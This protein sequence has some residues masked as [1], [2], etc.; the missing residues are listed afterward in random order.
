M[1]D[2]RGGG[3]GPVLAFAVLMAALLVMMLT[4]CTVGPD[5]ERPRMELPADYG[6]VQ[7]PVPPGQKWWSVFGDPVLD[8]VIDEALAANHDLKAAAERIEAARGRLLVARAPLTPDA[9]VRGRVSRDRAS[10]LGAAPIP[11]EYLETKTHRLELV[12]SW[13]LDFWGKYRRATEAARAELAATEAGRDAIR[14]TLIGDVV[15][16]YFALEALDR[17]LEVTLRTVEGREQALAMQKVRLDSGV[18]SELEYRQVESELRG[19]QALAPALRQARIRQEGALAVLLGR[20]PRE[21]YEGK[22]DTGRPAVSA[23]EVPAGLP[24]DLLLRRPDLRQAEALLHAASARIG[25][26]RAAYFPSITLTGSF[27]GESQ[28]L[29][30]LFSAQARTW[31]LAG[32]LLQPLFAG[33]QIR[34]NVQAAE[35]L[36]REAAEAYRKTVANAFREVR[37][38]LA[39]QSNLREVATAQRAREAA[40]SRTYELSRLRYDNGATSLFEVLE[41]ERQLLV[42]RLEAIDAERDRRDAIVDLYLA[43]GAS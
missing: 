4:G 14:A 29:G 13:E 21:V 34:G 6:V 42:V 1:S 17:R 28:A 22:V 10:Q 18:V 5:Y 20:T 12:A 33:G 19:A 15:R 43:L 38:A 7:S 41:T 40:L 31:S 23:V 37:E 24:S 26:A 16:G 39:A 36:A 9:G 35:A 27:G 3:R 25:V 2:M 30:D 8:R 11:P 32:G